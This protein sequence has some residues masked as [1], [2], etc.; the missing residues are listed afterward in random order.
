MDGF[1]TATA[2]EAVRAML[3]PGKGRGAS[4]ALAQVFGWPP[5]ALRHR[6]IRQASTC[7]DVSRGFLGYQPAAL[8]ATIAERDGA[9]PLES[10]ALYSYHSSTRWGII[11]DD[12]GVTVF[13]S[14]WV[15]EDQWFR[16]PPISWDELEANDEVRAALTPSGLAEGRIDRLA[17]RR[18]P[19][20]DVLQPVDDELVERLDKWRDQALRYALEDEGVDEQLQILFAQFFVLRT[21]EDRGLDE[22]I[23]PLSSA[24]AASEQVN[25]RRLR[26]IFRMA[27]EKIGGELFDSQAAQRLPAHVVAGVIQD[28]Y[29]PRLLPMRQLRYNFAWIESDVLG[30]AYE[31]YLSTVLQAAPPMSQMELFHEP[32]REIERISVRRRAG[33]YYTPVFIT[34]FLGER[35]VDEYYS[36]F[37]ADG[38]APRTIDF[39]CGSGSFLVAALDRILERLK[40]VDPDKKWARE[41]VDSGFIV[42]IDIDPKAVTAARLNLWQRLTE[43]P[44]PLPLPRLSRVIIQGD[45]LRRETWGELDTEYDIVL[46]NP[47]FLAT[48][49]IPN[50]EYLEATF[51]T[52]QGRFDFSYLFVEQ[53]TNIL[54]QHGMLGMVVPN[55]LYRNRYAEQIRDLLIKRCNLLT[56]VDFGSTVPF[57]ETSAYIG[58]VVAQRRSPDEPLPETVRVIEVKA[59]TP[60]FVAAALLEASAAECEGEA[61]RSYLA[62]HPR[63]PAAWTLL[64]EAERRSQVLLSDVSD[65]LGMLAAVYQGIRTGA[66]DIFMVSLLS[67]DEQQLCH[68]VNGLGEDAVLELDLLEPVVYGSDVQ[69][70]D[71]VSATKLLVYPYRDGVLLSQ[72][73]FQERYPRTLAYL[74]RYRDALASRASILGSKR[75]YEL[76]RPRDEEW[77]RQPKLLIRD[78][79]PRTSFAVDPVGEV[80]LVGG[81]AVVPS[82]PEL[83]TPLLAYLNSRTVDAL[84]RRTT[85]H[86]RGSFQKFEPQHIQR[87]PILRRVVDDEDFAEMLATLAREAIAAR[88]NDDEAA[89]REHE[90]SIDRLLREA[91]AAQGITVSD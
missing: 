40:K 30:L 89:F 17:L 72:A 14:H 84:V 18:K 45:A 81:T 47:P 74:L 25:L 56:I 86:F 6:E 46:G 27:R 1:E 34:Q 20:S 79:A 36:H 62:R 28:L 67:T 7:L 24:I 37:A 91:F 83:L 61:V 58:C 31:K 68:V 76:V 55:R 54:K 48:Q 71:I 10:A 4:G 2:I 15:S 42:G 53:A 63:G 88:Q 60:P 65:E 85:P 70:Y 51:E 82:R 22:S 80:F 21:V 13:N 29:T 38:V 12:R 26:Q 90:S 57:S 52:A 35:C 69:S 3:G 75:W 59:L 41:L 11:A 39:C 66:N 73:E 43:E 44:D 5:D 23:P 87:I 9:D 50:R 49:R 78:L 32:H 33:V 77:L 8:F 64:S 19:P 16:F